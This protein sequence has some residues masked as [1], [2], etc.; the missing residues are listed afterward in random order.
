M[1]NIIIIEVPAIREKTKK[2]L[3]TRL[4]SNPSLPEELKII[5]NTPFPDNQ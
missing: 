2:S 3:G 4:I 1:I 5:S